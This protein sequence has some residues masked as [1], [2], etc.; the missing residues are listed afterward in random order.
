MTYPIEESKVEQ[1]GE[2]EIVSDKTPDD[3]KSICELLE[4]M[5]SYCIDASIDLGNNEIVIVSKQ[6]IMPLGMKLLASKEQSN[7][8]GFFSVPVEEVYVTR[9]LITVRVTYV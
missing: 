2:F 5:T 6:S 3:C 9:H 1:S 4:M 8:F 7:F